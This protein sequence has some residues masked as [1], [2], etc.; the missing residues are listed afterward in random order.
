MVQ[1]TMNSIQLSSN[2]L[3]SEQLP[4]QMIPLINLEFGPSKNK[5]N[6]TG[7]IAVPLVAS[8]WIEKLESREHEA[9]GY[10]QELGCKAGYP[11]IQK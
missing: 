6:S 1:P 5:S 11:R 2:M 3:E 4:N 10:W 7:C 8:H 9:G